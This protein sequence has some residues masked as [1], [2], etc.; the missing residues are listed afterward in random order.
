MYSTHGGLS[1]GLWIWDYCPQLLKHQD[2]Q[3]T[4]ILLYAIYMQEQCKAYIYTYK[5]TT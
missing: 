3:I 4:G 1:G 5:Q 2:I